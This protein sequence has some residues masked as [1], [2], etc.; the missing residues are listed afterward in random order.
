MKKAYKKIDQISNHSAYQLSPQGLHGDMTDF[1]WKL[2]E[3]ITNEVDDTLGD[4][5]MSYWSII[6]KN[7]C[8][9]VGKGFPNK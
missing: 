7:N 4:R 2:C 6:Q 8:H 5:L 1:A 9:K 3:F